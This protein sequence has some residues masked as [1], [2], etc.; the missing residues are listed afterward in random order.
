MI[1]ALVR[2]ALLLALA[3]ASVVSAPR[4]AAAD[5]QRHILVLGR[6]SD[7]PKL[8]Y[9]QLKP[10]LDYVVP[11]MADVGIR[12]GRVLMARDAQQMASY[13]RRGQ[14]DWVTETAGT[15]M[16]LQQ[17][18]GAQPMLLTERDGVSR[19]RTLFLVRADS[20]LNSLDD[21][22]GRS[23]AFQ[24]NA[25]TSAYFVPT[26]ELLRH[27]MSLSLLLS[28]M[29]KP[30][31]DSV[32]YVFARSELNIGA[33]VHKRLVDAGAMSEL[34]WDN[35]ERVP[36]TFRR[37][38]VVIHRSEPVPR[39]LEMVRG[40]LDPRVQ[41]RLR[42]VLVEASTDPSAREA[43]RYFFRTT[44]FLP[45]DADDRRALDRLREGVSQVRAVVE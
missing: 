25:S 9:E 18:G 23:V 28:P 27:G 17:R 2:I 33:W 20:G 31:G 30:D 6:I 34:D 3:S 21:L 45:I 8:H 41:A 4:A 44:R 40:D 13:L 42:E 38:L 7:D 19:Y 15:A 43:L 16:L 26:I 37:D 35:P 32:G 1:A 29:D 5:D 24:N 10:L 22:R 12:E 11:R 39:A 36:P 14:V